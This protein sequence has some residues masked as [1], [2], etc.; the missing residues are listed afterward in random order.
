M[1]HPRVFE[2]LERVYHRTGLS[3]TMTT[4]GILI[5]PEE[6]RKMSGSIDQVRVSANTLDDLKVRGKAIQHLMD[7]GVRVGVNILVLRPY[8]RMVPLLGKILHGIGV[9]DFIYLYP[10]NCDEKWMPSLQAFRSLVED[11][12]GLG[13]VKVDACVGRFLNLDFYVDWGGDCGAGRRIVFID[14]L[15]RIHP[16]SFISQSR[17]GDVRQVYEE[18]KRVEWHSLCGFEPR[19]E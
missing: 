18:L 4:N 1:C 15:G 11:A 19:T 13:T 3:V 17:S 8:L 12:R 7:A 16:C 9:R 6:A 10:K 5:G 2:I 14:E